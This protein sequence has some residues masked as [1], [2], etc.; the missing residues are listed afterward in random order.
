[1]IDKGERTLALLL[2]ITS[3]SSPVLSAEPPPLS[4]EQAAEAEAN[5]QQYC[6]LCHGNDRQGYA[7]DHAPS[8][9][10]KSLM[11]SGSR[12]MLYATAYGRFGTP[13]AAYLDEMGGPMTVGEIYILVR[14]LQSHVVTESYEFS[15]DLVVGDVET[16]KRVY[17]EHCASCHG[18]MGEGGTGT[19]LGNAA[20]LSLTTDK[21]IRYAI[22]NGREGTEMLAFS[23]I[24]SDEEINGVTAFLRTR[25]TGWTVEKPVLRSP[26]K[27]GDYVLNSDSPVAEFELKEDLY[28]MSADLLKALRDKKRMVL[29]DT[30]SMSQW[31]VY[32]IEGSVPIPYYTN[33]ADLR[34]LAERLPN[35]GTMI[36][37]YCA[38]PRAAAEHVNAMIRN[39][40]FTN[41]AV[42]WEGIRGWVS[43]GYPVFQGRVSNRIDTETIELNERTVSGSP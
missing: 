9:R 38:C 18:K 22:E 26:P 3:L 10:S 34:A 33:H 39:L 16:G 41:T 4:E 21:F 30:R 12:E 11:T 31:Q 27:V 1:M 24:L 7:N 36:V 13:M 14:W 32:N 19:A 29:L 25:A 40:G 43:F 2:V 5:Y 37:T 28:V 35:D 6:A 8:L 42:L 15:R 23:G 20:M 17:S